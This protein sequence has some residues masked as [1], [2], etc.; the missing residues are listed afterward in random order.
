MDSLVSALKMN[1]N[2]FDISIG[3]MPNQVSLT[4]VSFVPSTGGNTGASASSGFIFALI[5]FHITAMN[6]R[7]L[8]QDSKETLDSAVVDSLNVLVESQLSSGSQITCQVSSTSPNTM[9]ANVTVSV[10]S[11]IGTSQAGLANFLGKD[12]SSANPQLPVMVAERSQLNVQYSQ[13]YLPVIWSKSDPVTDAINILP[14]ILAGVG[15]LIV[16][17]VFVCIKYRFVI[18]SFFQDIWYRI[19]GNGDS[20][21]SFTNIAANCFNPA[22]IVQ[23][24]K[25]EVTSTP[26]TATNV[27]EDEFDDVIMRSL[28]GS[29]PMPSSTSITR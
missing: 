19:C 23:R 2:R 17:I 15:L 11:D 26:D 5:D 29:G 6:V 4:S 28:R 27:D 3:V 13:G 18:Q 1:K 21:W 7:R 14:Y 16:G 9:V 12:A 8:M 25:S 22:S 10:K 24:G 20:H